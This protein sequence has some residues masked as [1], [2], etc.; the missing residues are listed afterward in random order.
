MPVVTDHTGLHF[1]RESAEKALNKLV[2]K[3][4]KHY[5]VTDSQI[6][7]VNE[8][9]MLSEAGKESIQMIE[10]GAI[11]LPMP[12]GY[13]QDGEFYAKYLSYQGWVC[14]EDPDAEA[15]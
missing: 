12:Q 9:K 10:S 2:K 8:Y 5:T 7:I 1:E 14:F 6:Q 4:E 13:W 3:L 15:Q 11:D